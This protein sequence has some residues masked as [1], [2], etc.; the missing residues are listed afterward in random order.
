MDRV[1]KLMFSLNNESFCHVKTTGY[2]GLYN[3]KYDL[4]LD[5]VRLILF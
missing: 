4:F 2:P 3:R 1:F 5:I